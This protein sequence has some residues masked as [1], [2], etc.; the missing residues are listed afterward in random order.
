[1]N[2]DQTLPKLEK[3]QG[4]VA[5]SFSQS[6]IQLIS[7]DDVQ[8]IIPLSKSRIYALIKARKF[9][10]PVKIGEH[11]ACWI[12]HEITAYR[13]ERIAARQPWEGGDT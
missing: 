3:K 7:F 9:P 2:D 6:N 11:R 5:P 10:P 12:R 4:T 8:S 13:D 1:M